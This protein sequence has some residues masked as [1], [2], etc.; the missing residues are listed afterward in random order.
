[1]EKVRDRLRE[2]RRDFAGVLRNPSLRRLE[3]AWAF[4]IVSTWAYGIAI[5][6]YAYE[7]GGASAA[8]LVGLL[9]WVA[10]AAASPFASLLGDRYDRRLVMVASDLL[11]AVLIGGAAVAVLTDSGAAIVYTLAALVS[12]AG[13]PFRP[14]EAAYTPALVTTPEELGAANVVSAA[15]ESVGIFAGPAL[16]GLLLAWTSVATT[17]FATAAA[18]VV[19]AGLILRIPARAVPTE[20]TSSAIGEELL[21]GVRAIMRNRKIA[22]LV[23][24]F[25][26][27]TFV[28][29]LL[30]VLIAVI[31]L[32]YIDA[33]ASA[34]G[35][36][37]AASGIGGL[38]GAAIAGVLV[39][40]GRL[41]GDFGAGVLLFGLPLALVAISNNEALALLLLGVVGVGNTLADVAGVTLLQ[42][43]TPDAVIGRVFGLLETLLLLTVGLGAA[44]APALVSLL[45]TRG[46]LVA[47]GILLPALVLSTWH[48]LR[49][50][51]AEA[52]VP[53]RETALL[54]GV[55]FLSSLPEATIERLAG[56][57]RREKATAGTEIIE[58]GSRGELF[59][60]IESGSVDVSLP[61]G[62]TSTLG[63]G[64]Y[65][66][67]IALLRDVP[68][69]ASVRA[70]QDT[71]L[72]VVARDDFLRAVTGHAP[73]LA[74]ADAVVGRRLAT[75]G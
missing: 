71:T 38:V 34:V 22:L 10:A 73:S 37:N 49:Q 15:I 21:A 24:L 14:A 26:A 32:S 62:S 52:N 28:D 1:M 67:E 8:G 17:F 63:E 45:G 11:R 4:S 48:V 41:A 6:V 60:V 57:A 64:D 56:L 46:A 7:Q 42:R 39:G 2:A 23:G 75:R 33:G 54:R 20:E 19:S 61:N 43:V 55:D 31:A 69:T 53:V 16:G 40:R 5:V 68:R 25:A 50:V 51:D 18:V 59:Y 66:G 74:S 36:L 29:G 9:R 3:L 65:F 27:Q 47:A 35:W 44:A 30:G 58:R 12:V 72:L 70:R 13:T